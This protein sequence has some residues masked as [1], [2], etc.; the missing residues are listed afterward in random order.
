[1]RHSP[2]RITP[3]RGRPHS[4]LHWTPLLRIALAACLGTNWLLPLQAQA[5]RLLPFQARLADAAGKPIPDGAT[6]VQFQLFSDPTNQTPVWS[7]EVHRTTVNGGLVNVVLGSKNPFPGNR[8]NE[9]GAVLS[10]FDAALFLEVTVDSTGKPDGSPDGAITKADPP[11]LP[12]QALIPAP[13]T[14]E[15]GNA[16]RLQGLDWST[17][18]GSANPAT[19]GI[20]GDRIQPASITAA[21]IAPN[22][23]DSSRLAPARAFFG[24][25]VPSYIIG[26]G[27]VDKPA[28]NPMEYQRW[29]IVST[30]FD[31]TVHSTGRPMWIGLSG[32]PAG[33]VGSVPRETPRMYCRN[34]KRSQDVLFPEFDLLIVNETDDM[35]VVA[36]AAYYPINHTNDDYSRC[37]S[38]KVLKP[39]EH[40]LRLYYRIYRNPDDELLGNDYIVLMFLR[41]AAI[42]F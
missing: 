2:T 26:K 41:I 15:S 21:Q 4:I 34:W 39:G 5:P 23:I 35:S 40:R 12:R 9:L 14:L 8:T 42:E 11:L 18:F 6:A 27:E 30:A 17:V 37:A 1:M 16:L 29:A 22:A 7:G 20:P 36:A 19:S 33:T 28:T 13:F 25:T 32:D 3:V 10:F 31:V 24:P 38:V